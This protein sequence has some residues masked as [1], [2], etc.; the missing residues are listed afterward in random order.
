MEEAAK[1]LKL[2]PSKYF[3]IFNKTPKNIV[4]EFY[5]KFLM[6]GH[7]IKHRIVMCLICIISFIITFLQ[8]MLKTYLH[9]RFYYNFIPRIILSTGF[10]V[11]FIL[12]DKLT[13]HSAA[14][15]TSFV[16]MIIAINFSFILHVLKKD[17]L[18]QY[19]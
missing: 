7:Y 4:E 18:D 16:W 17:L 11:M 6:K 5:N 1:Q 8:F 19:N 13:K 14:K 3:L 9:D 2:Y 15:F 10:L 12:I